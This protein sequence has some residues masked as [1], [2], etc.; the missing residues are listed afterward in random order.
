ML[1]KLETLTFLFVLGVFLGGCVAGGA[2]GERLSNGSTGDDL[3]N[4]ADSGSG[5]SSGGG[6]STAFGGPSTG[7]GDAIVLTDPLMEL[8]HIVD[9]FDGN[10]KSKVTLPK[11]YDGVLI[12][13]GLNLTRLRDG[14]DYYVRFKFGRFLNP[15]IRPAWVGPA[16][17]PGLTNT[18]TID[19]LHVDLTGEPFNGLRLTNHLYDYNQYENSEEPITDPFDG[20]L[21]C[22][23]LRLEHDPTF[24]GTGS[25]STCSSTGDKCLYAYATVFDQGLIQPSGFALYPSELQFALN[26]TGFYVN[27]TDSEKIKKCLSD[28]GDDTTTL[29]GGPFAVGATA[30]TIGTDNYTYNGPYEAR[31]PSSWNITDAA[32]HGADGNGNHWGLFENILVPFDFSNEDIYGVY[33]L[34]FPRAGRLPVRAG[35][36]YIGEDTTPTVAG[37]PTRTTDGPIASDLDESKLMDGC[38]LRVSNFDAISREGIGSCDVTGLIEIVTFD[39]ESGQYLVVENVSTKNL[40]VQLIRRTTKTPLEPEE[41]IE[42]SFRSCSS[43]SACAGDECCYNGRCWSKDIVTQCREDNDANTLLD[44]GETCGNDL[45]CKSLCCSPN[46]RKC[47][48]HNGDA[49]LC[50]KPLG[51]ACVADEFCNKVSQVRWI[52]VKTGINPDTGSVTCELRPF[53]VQVFGECK[54]TGSIGICVAPT[55]PVQPAFDP[56]DP[57]NCNDAEDPPT[58]LDAL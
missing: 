22:R 5:S 44:V 9:P 2:G 26:S 6:A 13:A 28:S 57:N 46:T 58:D 35:V 50:Q 15:I 38:N 53:N 24:E 34:L 10:Y 17:I 41:Y 14:G 11:N 36:E 45:E 16:P 23:A 1:R 7:E 51:T 31:A 18:L 39:K 54:L 56:T 49:D 21:Y 3:N 19:V 4:G 27:E 32:I 29:G 42:S 55:D 40:K 37:H 33:S 47:E 12:M 48:G 52:K 8:N 25:N 20:R 30:L 43:N